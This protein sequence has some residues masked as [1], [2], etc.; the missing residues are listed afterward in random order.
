[1]SLPHVTCLCSFGTRNSY[2]VRVP[3]QSHHSHTSNV[4]RAHVTCFTPCESNFL[5]KKNSNVHLFVFER[6]SSPNSIQIISLYFLC[7]TRPTVEC[8]KNK[9]FASYSSHYNSRPLNNMS[10]PTWFKHQTTLA[11]RLWSNP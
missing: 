4:Q 9:N 6:A 2:K 10:S 5:H 1:M 3:A 7:H 11:L 8:N